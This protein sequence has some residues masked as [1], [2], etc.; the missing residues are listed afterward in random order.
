MIVDASPV[1]RQGLHTVII[2]EPDLVVCGQASGCAEALRL[3]EATRP[4]VIIVAISLGDGS[5]L[6]LI[7][8]IKARTRPV[9]F[10]V[11]SGHDENL[12]AERALR[13]GALGFIEKRAPIEAIVDAIRRVCR[14]Q[15]YLSDRIAERLLHGLASGSAARSPVESLTNRE[16]EVF[17]FARQEYPARQIAAHLQL[18][19]ETV[20][21]YLRVIRRKLSIAR[22]A[23]L[24][25]HAAQ[26]AVR[27][28]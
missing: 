15:L 16:L 11:F 2:R 21:G 4:D 22:D 25:D 17:D 14:G 1:V 6:R 7:K 19:C 27:P 18:S 13:A 20:A 24:A 8:R 28:D 12:F 23:K 10:L 26:W 5:G 9:R 3:A